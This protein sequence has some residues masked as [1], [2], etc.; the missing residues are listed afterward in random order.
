LKHGKQFFHH[1]QVGSHTKQTSIMS[2][3][4]D[5]VDIVVDKSVAVRATAASNRAACQG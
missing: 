4:S 3:S 2:S 1:I 5:Y